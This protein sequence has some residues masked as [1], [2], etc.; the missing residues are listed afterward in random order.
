LLQAGVIGER[1]HLKGVAENII[2]GQPIS[3]GTGSVE[4]FYIP[5]GN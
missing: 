1:D 4:L 5:E 2:V 3:L